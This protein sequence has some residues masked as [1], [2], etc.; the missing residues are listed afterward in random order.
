MNK[1]I[2]IISIIICVLILLGISSVYAASGEFS[3]NKT[4]A[5]LEIGNSTTFTITATNCGGKFIIKSLDASVATVNSNEEWIENTSKEIIITAKKA[6]TAT[7]EVIAEDVSSTTEDEVIGSKC[8]TIT[9]KAPVVETPKEPEKPK[10]PETPTTTTPPAETTPKK[11]SEARLSN[12]GIKPNDFSGFKKDKTE[13]ST[14]VPNNVSE[15]EVYA[16]PIKGSNATVKGTG[17]V[18]L[19]E[20]NNDV[21][22]TVT[23]E[24]GT[25]TKTYTINIKRRT[26]AEEEK[27]NS[28]AGLKVLG[29]KPEQYD[30]KG[31][32]TDKT[33]YSVEVPNDVEQIEV[34]ATA[35]NAKAQITGT[36]I[37]DLNEG[38]NELP[39]E[40]IAVDG[41]KKTYTLKVTRKEAEEI[42]DEENQEVVATTEGLGLSTLT[43]TGLTISPK[44]KADV[45][46]YTIGLRED[47]TSLDINVKANDDDATVEIIGNENLQQGENI[48]TILLKNE[49]TEEAATYQI[50]VNKNVVIEEQ[51]SWLKPATWGKEEKIKIAIVIVLIALII[52]AIILKIKISNEEQEDKRLDLPGADELDKAIAE[53]QELSESPNEEQEVLD[54]NYI[55]EIARNKFAGNNEITNSFEEE[56]ISKPKGKGRHF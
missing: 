42:E 52:I 16:D 26:V 40:V 27:E 5:T 45:Y 44:F 33:E 21:K 18:A 1:R 32:K 41:T 30:F 46:E 34:Y 37:I 56:S 50:I 51:T 20:G 19:N 14:E 49:E 11:S 7:I 17:K 24:D 23:A 4:S 6:G 43:V 54:L 2:K 53:H 22:V 47:L 36:G 31:F 13:Y 39:I 38:E 8:I 25:T 9:V 35:T 10:E 15:V 48:I 28:E 12:L 55:E 29:I 3:V